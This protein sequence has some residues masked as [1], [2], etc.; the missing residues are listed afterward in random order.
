MP[1]AGLSTLR[2]VQE[3]EA[4]IDEVGFERLSLVAIARRLGVQVPSL[5][6]HIA[7]LESLHPLIAARAKADLADSLGA[8]AVGR[9]ADAAVVAVAN[10]YRRWALA[11]PGR[12]PSTLRAPDAAD[13]ADRAESERLVGIVFDILDGYGLQGDDAVD[14][15]RALRATLHGF[16]A[17]EAAGGFGLPQDVDRSFARLIDGFTSTLSTAGLP[18]PRSPR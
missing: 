18:Q 2:V 5:Y 1:R 12:Y 11:H 9:S 13:T 10:E 4:V 16:V 7:G 8:V 15:T 17:L 6:K 3:A 14:A